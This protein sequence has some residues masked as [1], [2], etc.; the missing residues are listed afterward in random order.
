[1]RKFLLLL[2]TLLVSVSVLFYCVPKARYYVNYALY[3]NMD[4]DSTGL[5]EKNKAILRYAQKN[6]PTISPTYETA[7]CTEYLIRIL[8][9]FSKL[10]RD[11]KNKIS[12][13]TN[14]DI[15]V[16]L[17]ENSPIP[18]G[19]CYA[20]TS[21]GLGTAV[22]REQVLAGDFVQFWNTW[23]GKTTGHCGIVRAVDHKK[24]LISLYSS[25]PKTDGHGKQIYVMPD[26]IFFARLK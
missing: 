23:K 24:G 20:L 7:V 9:N 4:V 26:Y 21:S 3:K 8:N 18:Q 2:L 15:E 19:V 6:G 17:K 16:L 1:M 12:I 25:S 14:R 22:S 5:A 10:N 11:Q 13:I